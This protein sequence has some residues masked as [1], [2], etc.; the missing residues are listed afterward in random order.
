MIL[1]LRAR[2]SRMVKDP[3]VAIATIALLTLVSIIL[4]TQIG[5][6]FV[7]ILALMAI[8]LCVGVGLNILLGLSGQISF[9]HVGFF[10]IGAYAVGI[11]T[12]AGWSFWIALPMAML[13]G[14]VT[15]GLLALPALRVSGPYLAMM[16][17][18][19]AFIVEHGA[20]EWRDLTGGQNGLMGFP[21]PE[22][23][24]R[25]FFEME[26]AILAILLAGLS[27]VLY[28]VLAR[29]HWGLAMRA[30]SDSEVA[31][32]SVGIDPLRVKTLAF[33]LSAALAALAGGLFTPLQ[34]FIS[35]GSFPFFQSILFLLAVV[36]GGSRT[37]LGPV[38]G[39][40]VTVLLPELLSGLAEYR[41]LFFG[42]LM[43]GVLL[44]APRGMMGLLQ[45]VLIVEDPKTAATS[46]MPLSELVGRQGTEVALAVSNLS[47]AF[48]GVRAAQDVSFT[49]EPGR[50]TSI[51]GPNGAG[52][53]TVL[54]MI[55][56][57]Y[58]PDSGSIRLDHD[59]AG[60]PAWAAARAGIA[61]TYQTTQLFEQLSVIDNLLTAER[62]GSLGVPF[63]PPPSESARARAE[64]L[65][66]FVGYHGP[67]DREA[68]ALPHVDR[69]LVEIARALATRPR[70]LLLD[71]PAAGLSQSD[72]EQ[73][74]LL[75]RQIAEV[76]IAVVLVEHDMGLVMGVSDDILVL[77]AGTPIA[78]GAPVA[79]R[80]DPA[81]LRAYLGDNDYPGRPRA[82]PWTGERVAVL[83]AHKLV[84]G[85]GA[86]P[87]LQ[88]IDI[89]VDPAETVA[90]LGAN[91]AGKSTLMR[92]LAGLHRPVEGSVLLDDAE[93]S[94]TEAHEIA[95]HGLALVPEGR[96][97]F[98]ELSVRD[99]ILLG[100]FTRKDLD[101]DR[102]IEALLTRFPRLRDRINMPAGVLSGGE[103]QMLAV[104]RGLIAKPRILLL[105]EP[106]LGLAPAMVRE[107]FDTLAD[108]RDEGVTILLVDQMATLALAISDRA[109]VLENG[110]VVKTGTA[111]DLSRDADVEQAYLGAAE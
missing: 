77:D 78:H 22:A 39:V 53:T 16:T 81:V 45:R 108:L 88:Q 44:A 48:G 55:G 41:L 58:V 95:A 2:L 19:F 83:G 91:G 3:R 42:G 67:L 76:G 4:A 93:I 52:K 72:K 73:L 64:G 18:A 86:A 14:A 96:Q 68:A 13:L 70:V 54:N 12:L 34:G 9:G 35:P 46:D 21:A 101:A 25:V 62:A 49:A 109:Y 20:I 27:L 17:I 65:L 61:R 90:I 69:R 43:L 7:F 87:V 110:E 59:L 85:Y 40:L 63:G 38:L 32:Q 31:A 8:N 82:A 11:A 36:V 1:S 80:N 29:G 105:D 94:G 84:A 30:V 111:S 92:A 98:P 66:V 23:F 33:V 74:A 107:L 51:I 24:G 37:L 100:A 75:L 89:S 103:Q 97:V 50:I 15:G 106:S 104:A 47:I 79:V 71:E 60:Q 57:F 56:G 28:H 99:N 6:Y 10:L 102:E 26:M 5:G